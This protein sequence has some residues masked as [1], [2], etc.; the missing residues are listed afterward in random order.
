MKKYIILS[1]FLSI[2]NI[3]LAQDSTLI[4]R[5][6]VGIL[7]SVPISKIAEETPLGGFGLHFRYFPNERSGFSLSY[8]NL[9]ST[10]SRYQK[11]SKGFNS[12]L[13]FGYEK[14]V[15]F[16]NFSP[17]IGLEVGINIIKVNS[18]LIKLPSN[19]EFFQN[20]LP[21]Y[22]I[23]PKAGF[24]YKINDNLMANVEGTYNWVFSSDRANSNPLFDDSYTA[25]Y[26]GRKVFSVSLG[27][28]YL[29]N[30]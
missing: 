1:I 22:L 7:G 25:L 15:P 18:E 29:F 30:E 21:N 3:I 9:R 8:Q 12:S 14:H 2:S 19:I 27:V 26:F 11:P 5:F 13:G 16:G 28:H 24:F 6:S 10:I 20:N 4:G 23:K 17:Y